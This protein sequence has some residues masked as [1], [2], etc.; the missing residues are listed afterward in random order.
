LCIGMEHR[1]RPFYEDVGI[2]DV[3]PGVVAPRAKAFGSEPA[4][5]RAGRDGWQARILGHPA[6]QFGAAPAREW[7]LL[8]AWQATGQGGDLCAHLRGKNA[9]APHCEARQPT[10]AS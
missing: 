7:D 5:Y 4:T 8:L 1:A 6:R 9:S 3:L 10:N 2:M